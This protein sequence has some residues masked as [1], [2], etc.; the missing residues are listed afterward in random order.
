MSVRRV[1]PMLLGVWLLTVIGLVLALVSSGRRSAQAGALVANEPSIIPG[2]E[3]V[4]RAVPPQPG[5]VPV[6]VPPPDANWRLNPFA[7]DAATINVTYAGTWNPQAQAA[8]QYAVDIWAGLL[9]SSVA[10][11]LQANWTDLGAASG[12]L[13][14]ASSN[15]ITRDFPGAPAVGTWFANALADRR[16][17]ADRITAQTYEIVANFNSAFT[18][19]YF[20]TDGLVPVNKWDLATVVLHELGHG[21]G[22]AGSMQYDDGSAAN[23]TECAGTAGQGCWGFGTGFPMIYDRFVED[24]S[25]VSLLNTATYPNPS[26]ALGTRL[27]GNVNSLRWNGLYGIAGN[28]GTKPVLYSPTTWQGGSSYSHFDQSTYATELMKPALP[29]QTAIHNPGSRT[30]GVLRDSGWGQELVINAFA[31]SPTGGRA[32]WVQI[33]NTS[34]IAIS[35]SDYAIGDEE[36]QGAAGEGSFLLPNVSL[37]SGEVFLMRIRSDAAWTY[38]TQPNPTYCWNCTS[39]YTN[40]T[41]YTL[42]G[43]TVPDL[44]NAGDE[45]V[46]LRT[47]GGTADVDGVNDDTIVDAMCYGTGQT[48]VDT[49]NSGALDGRDQYIFTDHTCLSTLASGSFQ[50]PGTVNTCVPASAYTDN[51]TA[52]T[53]TSV[54]ANNVT[55]GDASPLTPLALLLVLVVLIGPAV[56]IGVPAYNRR[57]TR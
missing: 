32:E 26:A 11:D 29:P 19:W 34:S 25:T 39:G 47:N 12:I 20:G 13:G 51:P 33:K 18:D 45:I 24:P 21:L 50:R 30:L 38:S 22:F 4:I 23:G 48:Y 56:M 49:N 40:L 44:A 28:G 10:I 54:E 53:L 2:P 41:Q 14:S 17:C 16:A 27:T 1:R 46:L 36:R 15:S 52:I 8:F 43:G 9:D 42:W 35:L 7:P 55:N 6:F 31:Y 5:A 37:A 57:R 3:L